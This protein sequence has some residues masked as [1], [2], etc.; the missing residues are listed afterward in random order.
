M[1]TTHLEW[2]ASA[3]AAAETR[4]T[5]LA[6]RLGG[7]YLHATR[8]GRYITHSADE[9]TSGFW[10]GLLLLAY[11]CS[12]DHELLAAATAAEVG[13]EQAVTDDRLLLLHHDV[14]FQFS[15]TAVMR[16]KLTSDLAARRRGFLAANLLMGRFN[17][18]GAF[19][20][21]WNTED[22]RGLVIIDTM[23][24]LPL[25]F[26]AAETFN[27]PRFRNVAI[28][29][30]RTA[31]RTH[32][33]PSGETHHVVRFDQETGAPQEARGGQGYAPD[34]C[35]SRGQSWALYGFALAYR[36]THLNEFLS[37]ACRVADSFIAALPPEGVPPWD[38]AAPDAATS[39]R[40][41]SAGAIAASGLLELATLLPSGEGL[42]YANAAADLLHALTTRCGMLHDPAYDAL[43]GHATGNLPKGQN[44]DVSLIYGDYYYLEALQKLEGL[45]ETCW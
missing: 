41:S 39:P 15:P 14:G 34:S 13:L 1:M 45:H 12:G 16:Y 24:N 7:A 11:R 9:W 10:P 35:W 37:T 5:T 27:Q 29:H 8:E 31:M 38:F 44:I 21:A 42:P 43:L 32:V 22:R 3:R 20:E 36:Y 33:R 23:M 26:W 19:I 4:V 17:P 28:A 18:V 40:D 6:A 2:V 25:L 30:A